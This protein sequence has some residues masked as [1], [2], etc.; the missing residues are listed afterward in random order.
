MTDTDSNAG[1]G[2]DDDDNN[3][4][5]V[6]AVYNGIVPASQRLEAFKK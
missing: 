5:F 6:R 3:F 4:P 2:D 1:A